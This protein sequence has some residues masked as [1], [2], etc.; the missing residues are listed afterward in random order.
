MQAKRKLKNENFEA[1]DPE[2]EVPADMKSFKAVYEQAAPGMSKELREAIENSNG[3]Y[4]E[5]Y[6]KI[7]PRIQR[8][9]DL[10]RREQRFD[11]ANSLR[12]LKKNIEE[13]QTKYVSGN[14]S[15]TGKF[16]V[17]ESETAQKADKAM[18]YYKEDYTPFKQGPTDE[19]L[20]L[21][22]KNRFKPDE[23]RSDSRNVMVS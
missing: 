8:D 22:D 4:G 15:N 6:T 10:A 5:L 1:I 20:D 18:K 13:D 12:A 14:R 21:A 19:I 2:H 11:D 9:I 23:F 17:A 3:S 7:R 16:K